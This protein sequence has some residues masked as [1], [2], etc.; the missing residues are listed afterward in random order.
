MSKNTIYQLY[1]ELYEKHGDPEVIWPQWCAKK[2]E[3]RTRELVA[4]GAILTQRT[5]W[6]NADLA[7]R[8]LKNKNLLSLEKLVALRNLERLRELIRPAGFYQTKPKRIF[9]FASFIVKQYGSLEGFAAEKLESAREKLLNLY[10]IG[11]ETADTILLYA[12]DRPTFVI[13]AYTQKFAKHKKLSENLDYYS[14]KKLFEENLPKDAVLFQ[15]FHTLII[16]EQKGREDSIM[17]SL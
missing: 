6:R 1:Q 8:N 7:L 4:L 3:T 15:N 13:D 17:D 11:P 9:T 16:V 10:G 14:L 12:A 5:S 2:K